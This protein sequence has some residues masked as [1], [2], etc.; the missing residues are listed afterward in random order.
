MRTLICALTLTLLTL[1]GCALQIKRT[2]YFVSP[3]TPGKLGQAVKGVT[4]FVPDKD[5]NLVETTAD[6]PAGTLVG[7]PKTPDIPAGG[8][9]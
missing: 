7:V 9:K 5:G 3:G 2:A 4:V 6:L 1:S 8:T